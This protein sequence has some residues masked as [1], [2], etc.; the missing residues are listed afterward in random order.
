[1][2]HYSRDMCASVPKDIC[3]SLSWDLCASLLQR[4]MYIIVP[5][6]YVYHYFSGVCIIIS[7]IYVHHYLWD[8]CA[9]SS[10]F[11]VQH[12]MY[13]RVIYASYIPDYPSWKTG[14]QSHFCILTLIWQRFIWNCMQFSLFF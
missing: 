10:P 4:Y 14:A 2:H 8:V 11:H 9:S 13:I 6:I 1:M 5:G 12:Y 3:A 7:W